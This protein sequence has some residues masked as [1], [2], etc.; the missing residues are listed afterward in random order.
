ME[1]PEAIIQ[2]IIVP[3]VEDAKQID[4]HHSPVTSSESLLKMILP[5]DVSRMSACPDRTFTELDITYEELEQ[6]AERGC[7]V[8]I[9]RYDIVQKC[10]AGDPQ[11][12]GTFQNYE[13]DDIFNP[14]FSSKWDVGIHVSEHASIKTPPPGR[15]DTPPMAQVI[16]CDTGSFNTLQTA[17]NWIVNCDQTHK[18]KTS[19]KSSLPRRIL[20]VRNDKVR[21]HRSE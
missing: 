15:V 1:Q 10:I 6:R 2:A 21:L 19:E 5:G 7:P 13:H 11:I 16:T 14:I 20:D 12:D 4:H 8:C 9:F 3:P 17:Q 18:C